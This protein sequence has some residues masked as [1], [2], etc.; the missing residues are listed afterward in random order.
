MQSSGQGS[1]ETRKMSRKGELS[2][3]E[4][5]SLIHCRNCWLYTHQVWLREEMMTLQELIYKRT[6]CIL[7]LASVYMYSNDGTGSRCDRKALRWETSAA[8][9]ISV[10]YIT[11]KVKIVVVSLGACARSGAGADILFAMTA[12][13][14]MHLSALLHYIFAVV[15]KVRYTVPSV[16]RATFSWLLFIL[17]SKKKILHMTLFVMWTGSSVRQFT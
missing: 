1:A 14:G 15:I 17:N 7:P 3:Q 4:A 11:N 6:R 2:G 8:A 13:F 12:Q 10:G 5:A 16:I 9:D